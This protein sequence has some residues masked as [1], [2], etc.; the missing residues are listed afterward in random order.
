[1]KMR[2]RCKVLLS[3]WD[4]L[5]FSTDDGSL[6]DEEDHSTCTFVLEEG[7]IVED[8]DIGISDFLRDLIME[9]SGSSLDYCMLP[10]P[11]INSPYPRDCLIM[12]DVGSASHWS[13]RKP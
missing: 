12:E 13:D 7:E 1:M 11:S 4:R 5:N 2:A 6:S 8:S 3:V 10:I 9:G